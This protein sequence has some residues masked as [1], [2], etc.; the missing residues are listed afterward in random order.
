MPDALMLWALRREDLSRSGTE[1]ATY[2]LRATI[3][4]TTTNLTF[5]GS[6]L[7][8]GRSYWTSDDGQGDTDTAGGTRDLILE[9]QACLE[10]HPAAP[11]VGVA[12]SSVGVLT[13]TCSPAVTVLWGNAAT[14]L[15]ALPFGFTQADTAS[16]TTHVAPNQAWGWY[17]PE[18]PWSDDSRWQQPVV[19]VAASSL[20]GLTRVSRFGLPA[21]ER[22]I[23]LVDV[24]Q[25]RA[26]R[27][28]AP[29]TRP[30]GT[31]EDLWLYALSMGREVRLYDDAA[32]R[33]SSDYTVAVLG[34]GVA[35]RPY[36]RDP[37]Y[38]VHWRLNLELVE[39][40]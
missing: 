36:Q 12:M 13:L 27:E 29:A 16:A 20:S 26:L 3:S 31:I 40:T 35:D 18:R 39:R 37:E 22:S 8:R 10:T 5:G 32:A 30:R 11:T 4:G 28:Y 9:L 7:T 34:P 19:R 17:C 1:A 15:S 2:V 25:Q 6:G 38:P 23:S 14:T 24:E 33:S 21:R